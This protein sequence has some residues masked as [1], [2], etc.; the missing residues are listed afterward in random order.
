MEKREQFI[1]SVQDGW[2]LVRLKSVC[3]S[4]GSTIDKKIDENEKMV[5]LINY[6]DV[7][8]S[9]D[10]K[11]DSRISFM[12]VTAN[13][14]QRDSFGVKIGDIIMTPSSETAEDIGQCALVA[15]DLENTYFSYHVWRLRFDDS[16]DNDFKRYVLNSDSIRKYWAKNSKGTTRKTLNRGPMMNTL[17]PLPDLAI[18]QR[19]AAFLDAE[20]SKI[21]SLSDELTK[22]KANLQLQKRSLVSECVTKGVPED[23]DRAYKDSGVEWLGNYPAA[24]KQSKMK[25]ISKNV[26]I[27]NHPK[28]EM[29]SLYREYGV[30]KKSD[31]DD[32]HNATSDNMES[33]KLVE[34]GNLV[35]N[36]MKAWQGSLGISPYRGIISPA[37]FILKITNPEISLSY[38]HFL[39]RSPL[40]IPEYA[41]ISSGVRNGQWDLDMKLFK[42]ITVL[43][44]NLDEQQRIADYLDTECAK[45]DTLIGEIDNQVNLLKTYR[46]S[47]INEVVT[48]KVE[49]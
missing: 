37:Y 36:K 22:F 27:K 43:I 18:Q 20:T 2:R 5:N 25:N 11:I 1:E 38:L 26:S 15:E 49:V 32:N 13:K 19:I 9:L 21:D 42:E 10:K 14:Q 7:Y 23:R 41:R 8:N 35:I 34:V 4:S 46:K 16:V 24:W 28:E 47:L 40:Y 44:P 39:L 45:I 17:I 30:I 29:L 31:R 33:Y 6:V 12:K 3:Q 48:G